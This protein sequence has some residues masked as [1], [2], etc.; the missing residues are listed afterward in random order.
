MEVDEARLLVLFVT[1]ARALVLVVSP[2]DSCR[3][4]SGGTGEVAVAVAVAVEVVVGGVVVGGEGEGW[5][6][7]ESG[8]GVL[9]L[10]PRRVR[11][12]KKDGAEVDDCVA[13]SFLCTAS[14]TSWVGD[15]RGDEVG[16]PSRSNTRVEVSMQKLGATNSV[17]S[18][19]SSSSL[20]E[21][22]RSDRDCSLGW[23][24]SS[25]VAI[26]GEEEF[27][28]DS[29]LASKSSTKELCAFN[30]LRTSELTPS[31]FVGESPK[32]SEKLS[33]WRWPG[34]LG[35][36]LMEYCTLQC[37]SAAIAS[38]T[39]LSTSASGVSI[40]KRASI[41]ASPVVGGGVEVEVEV[42][43]EGAG[44]GLAV[45]KMSSKVSSMSQDGQ[46]GE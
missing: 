20:S 40:P 10:L 5:E 4:G 30:W 28:G 39:A 9:V 2:T 8:D 24:E 27:E 12:P 34:V 37:R 44:S 23:T 25:A 6:G 26:A 16:E 3:A 36:P 33:S 19:S 15:A 38:R 45:P 17:M 13:V 21:N 46:R 7:S 41:S 35:D 42:E 11:A 43:V 29:K 22:T 14:P 1:R 18:S 31:A 32:M